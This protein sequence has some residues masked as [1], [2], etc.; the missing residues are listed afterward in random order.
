MTQSV[1][2]GDRKGPAVDRIAR[3]VALAGVFS[4]AALLGWV[5]RG[6][7]GLEGAL[8]SAAFLLA[9]AGLSFA[10]RRA[11]L[12]RRGAE[13]ELDREPE[14][15]APRPAARRGRVLVID[16]EP[17][18]GRVIQRALR[19]DDDVVAAASGREALEAIQSEGDFDAVLCDVAM[20]EITGIEL[21][22]MLR[23]ELPALAERVVFISGGTFPPEAR[24]FLS[25]VPNQ[26]IAKPF[27]PNAVR[28]VV[29]G[30]IARGGG[31]RGALA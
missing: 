8:A 1:S 15:P 26:S 23:A 4:G 5:V 12:A 9:A 14:R 30:M 3:W 25:A 7:G 21:Y 10:W 17:G 2:G 20:S 18:V 11:A 19:S 13:G 24:E 22:R 28:A 31:G 6:L 27:D 29:A 16:G